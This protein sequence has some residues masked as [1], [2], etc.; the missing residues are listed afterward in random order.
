MH[1]GISRVYGIYRSPQ[2]KQMRNARTLLLSVTKETMVFTE[3]Q[4]HEWNVEALRKFLVERGVPLSGG[5]RKDDLI[6]KCVFAQDLLL[7]VLLSAEKKTQKIKS[8]PLQ[9][10]KTDHMQIPLPDELVM[11]WVAGSSCFPDVNID[12]LQKY[13][14]KSISRK[15]L[16]EGL[17]L[18]NAQH[19][20]NVEFNNISDSLSY[21]FV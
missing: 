8:R 14:V 6:R 19:I 21:C 10:L 3:D 12:C 4:L 20:N 7:P 11:A 5:I 1:F 17:N 2:N 16:K 15:G 18:Q 9:T 13:A